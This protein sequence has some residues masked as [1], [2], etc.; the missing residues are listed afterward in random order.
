MRQAVG[1][2]FVPQPLKLAPGPGL[3]LGG[4]PRALRRVALAQCENDELRRVHR[5]ESSVDP[6]G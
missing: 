5:R 4:T 1:S 6:P 2:R 3:A